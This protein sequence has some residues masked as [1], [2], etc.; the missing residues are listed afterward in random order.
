MDTPSSLRAFPSPFFAGYAQRA[1][2]LLGGKTN[3]VQCP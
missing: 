1:A 2:I 3:N